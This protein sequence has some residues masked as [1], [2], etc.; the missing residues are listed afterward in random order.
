[1]KLLIALLFLISSTCFAL[2]TGEK[3]PTFKLTGLSKEVSLGDYKGKIVV[4]EW[5]NHG[6]PFVRKH[7]DSGNMQALQKKYTEKGVVWFSVISS[8]PG[9][10]GHVDQ[11]GALKEKTANK[12]GATDILLDP[13]GEVGKMYGAKTS[14]HMYI[15]NKEGDLV[16]QGAIDDQPDT[17]KDSI[18]TAKNYVAKALDEVLAG[19]K[20]TAHT[21]RSYGCAVKY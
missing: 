2:T 9:K 13:T 4:L 15:I 3:A 8:A 17:E 5:L 12:S 19:K 7:Y 10:Q 11:A 20:V 1:M 6:C 18:A 16:Y 21:T 14:P